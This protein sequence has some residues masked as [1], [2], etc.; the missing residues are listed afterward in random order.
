MA[1][2]RDSKWFRRVSILVMTIF[3]VCAWT[4][5]LMALAKRAP[6]VGKNHWNQPIDTWGQFIVL[7][8]VTTFGAFWLVR[9]HRWWL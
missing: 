5:N 2:L 7:A 1:S 8:F 9:N 6:W 4:V 3:L